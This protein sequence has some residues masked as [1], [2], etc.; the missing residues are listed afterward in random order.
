[1]KTLHFPNKR[2]IL[3]GGVLVR[4]FAGFGEWGLRRMRVSREK[5]QDK[6]G[7]KICVT[8][9]RLFVLGAHSVLE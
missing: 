5:T 9:G 8:S 2:K 6:S 3:F 1:L 7:D 4:D